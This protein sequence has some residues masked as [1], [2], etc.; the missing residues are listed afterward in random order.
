ML[1]VGR[2]RC[3]TP[4]DRCCGPTIDLASAIVGVSVVVMIVIVMVIISIAIVI[5]IVSIVSAVPLGSGAGGRAAAVLQPEGSVVLALHYR[6]R[7]HGRIGADGR[8]AAVLY[9][10]GSV[11]P[12]CK[13]WSG[14]LCPMPGRTRLRIMSGHRVSR[15]PAAQARDPLR[16]RGRRL[17]HERCRSNAARTSLGASALI[18]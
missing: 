16:A 6:H 9:P 13:A 5:A 2:P 3:C 18:I 7:H 4:R 12:A 14:A 1:T 8:T 11:L 17:R 15:R 10:E